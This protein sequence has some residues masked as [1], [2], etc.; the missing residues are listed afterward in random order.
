MKDGDVV[1]ERASEAQLGDVAALLEA[2]DLPTADVREKLECFYVAYAS[3]GD[4]ESVGVVGL[5]VHAS[6]GLLRSLVVREGIRGGGYGDGIRASVE[7][8]AREAGVVD[9]YLLTTTAASFFAARGYERVDREAAPPAIRDT[10]EFAE[11]CS[12]AATCMRKSL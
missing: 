7:A 3:D 10:S 2:N 12:D 6:A 4:G 11:L 8:L 1:L 5:E 9:L